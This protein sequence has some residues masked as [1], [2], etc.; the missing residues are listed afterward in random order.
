MELSVANTRLDATL[1]QIARTSHLIAHEEAWNDQQADVFIET[2]I[3]ERT[4]VVS[5]T[6]DLFDEIF[7]FESQQGS[8]QVSRAPS[9][10]ET[11][12]P[13]PE[14]SRVIGHQADP[15]RG[16]DINY[17]MQQVHQ[18]DA[19]IA[20]LRFNI[21]G[22]NKLIQ[23]ENKRLLTTIQRSRCHSCT[24]AIN[25]VVVLK[26]DHH[27]CRRCLNRHMAELEAKGKYP[28]ICPCCPREFS[29]IHEHDMVDFLR[30][31]LLARDEQEL[32]GYDEDASYAQT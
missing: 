2:A 18:R 12:V 10:I 7:N 32:K 6:E 31:T 11:I 23:F 30:Y 24:K 22:L 8:P 15:R 16:Q 26:C 17:W 20:R 4:H 1:D 25:R 27:F 19:E 21:N 28:K 29:G 3:D 14:P 13:I 9:P 5:P